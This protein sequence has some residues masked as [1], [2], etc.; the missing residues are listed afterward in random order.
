MIF[1]VSRAGEVGIDAEKTSSNIDGALIARH[2][3]S[4]AEQARFG[5]LPVDQRPA[6]FFAQWVVKEA[7]LKGTGQGLDR[8]ERVTVEWREDGEPSQSETG[9]SFSITEVRITWRLLPFGHAVRLQ[10]RALG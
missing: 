1:L 10:L 9:N 7:Y 5:S 3:F 2:F 4:R 8:P 6:W